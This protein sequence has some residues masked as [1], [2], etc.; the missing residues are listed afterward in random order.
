MRTAEFK[1]HGFKIETPDDWDYE[2]NL[3]W[4][5]PVTI[6]FYRSKTAQEAHRPQLKVITNPNVSEYSFEEAQKFLE[7]NAEA[8]RVTIQSKGTLDVFGKKI[9]TITIMDRSGQA[10]KYIYAFFNKEY[11]FVAWLGSFSEENY[12]E[13]VKSFRPL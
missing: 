3:A 5:K 6:F 10:M 9:P 8:D 13:M 4:R 7:R 12:D 11:L 1:K 2:V